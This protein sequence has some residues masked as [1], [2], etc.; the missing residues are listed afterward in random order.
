[1][2]NV[3]FNILVDLLNKKNLTA[4]YFA[5]KHEISIRTVYRYCESM[6][7][8]GVPVVLRRGKNGGISIS[9]DLLM[10]NTYF[11]VEEFARMVNALKAFPAPDDLSDKVTKKLLML[12]NSAELMPALL[13]NDS[14]IVENSSWG[15]TEKYREKAAVIADAINKSVKLLLKYHSREGEVT[16][17]EVEPHAFVLKDDVW[18][19]FCF[20]L[21]RNDFRL[22]KLSRIERIEKLPV[23]FVKRD[24]SGYDGWR[25]DY[26]AAKAASINLT[27][28]IHEKIR[29]DV[30]EWLGI[31]AVKPSQTSREHYIAGATV[32]ENDMLIPKLLSYAPYVT[33][34]SP[35]DLRE[36]LRNT[37]GELVKT[38]G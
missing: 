11:T 4:Q 36:K 35:D 26:E 5:A 12:S 29:Y 28:K 34:L 14:I 38:L 31:E 23:K 37:V 18:Y 2:V 27:L 16:E 13:K 25:L 30:E 24:T 6:Q 17:R 1:M 10:K 32:A 19:V 33:V 21:H 15:G 3:M 20:C 8:A 9:D 7:G 22:F